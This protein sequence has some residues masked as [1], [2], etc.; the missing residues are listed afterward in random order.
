MLLRLQFL[1]IFKKNYP[2][3]NLIFLHVLFSRKH[4]L[5]KFTI[6]YLYSYAKISCLFMLLLL[7]VLM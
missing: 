5:P 3:Y 6:R 4:L 2:I 1:C 7:N